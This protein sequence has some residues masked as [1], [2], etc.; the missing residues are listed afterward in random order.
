MEAAAGSEYKERMSCKIAIEFFIAAHHSVAILILIRINIFKTIA[1]KSKLLFF[2]TERM[3]ATAY[4]LQ[5]GEQR[6]SGLT[7]A[8]W[9]YYQ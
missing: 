4:S 3:Y 6:N 2:T 5:F 7:S 9:G 8:T 1:Y